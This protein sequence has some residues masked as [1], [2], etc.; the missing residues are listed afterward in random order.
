[1]LLLLLLATSARALD[2]TG[3]VYREDAVPGVAVT[4]A[5]AG[6]VVARG[7]TGDDG[8]FVFRGLPDGVVEIASEGV[9]ALV[10]SSDPVTIQLDV[11]PPRVAARDAASAAGGTPAFRIRGVV[12][13]NGKPL[14]HAPVILQA[15]ADEPIAPVRVYANAR[16]EFEATGLLAARYAV[17][18]DERLRVRAP[19]MSRMYEEGREPFLVDLTSA[20]QATTSIELTAAPVIRGRVVDA[21]GKAVA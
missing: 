9:T 10:F 2:V 18:H 12:T 11:P 3:F 19:H 5:V 8:G 7:V 17:V 13:L 16:G 20:K 14:A 1:M 4:A 15:L 6:N 21:E